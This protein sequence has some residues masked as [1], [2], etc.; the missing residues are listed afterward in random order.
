MLNSQEGKGLLYIILSSFFWSVAGITSKYLMSAG[1]ASILVIFTRNL[2]GTA[3]LGLFLFFF[4][5]SCFFVAKEDRKTMTLC[6]FFMAVYAACYFFTLYFLDATIAVMLLYLYPSM[7]AV[8]SVFLYHE[9]LTAKLVFVLLITFLGLALILNAFSGDL[10]T[11]NLPG[12]TLGLIAAMAAAAY[13]IYIKKLSGK[14]HSFTINFYGLVITVVG[15]ALLLPL[16]DLEPLGMKYQ[17]VACAAAF[18]YLGGFLFYAAGVACLRP[19]FASIFGNFE[20]VFNVILAVIILGEV[21]NVGQGIGMILI[22]GA[23]V[24]LE[25]NLPLKK[26]KA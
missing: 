14:Y 15:F 17:I 5:R 22:L 9:P 19:S 6:C 3:C 20:S 24:L 21:F 18:P 26:K 2:F 25:V 4:R 13:C 7:V 12:L 11:V 8:A 1:C 10:G 16:F 23:I